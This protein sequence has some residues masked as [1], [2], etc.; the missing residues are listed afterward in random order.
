M[1]RKQS[2]LFDHFPNKNNNQSKVYTNVY[3]HKYIGMYKLRETIRF[4]YLRYRG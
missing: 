4:Q 1:P 3:L 2:N